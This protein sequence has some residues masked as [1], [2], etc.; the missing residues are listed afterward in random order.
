MLKVKRLK[1]SEE[2]LKIIFYLFLFLFIFYFNYRLPLDPDF[3][4]HLKYGEEVVLNKRV[5]TRDIFSHTFIGKEIIDTEWLIEALFYLIFSY[6]S[7]WGLSFFSA[8]ITTFAFFLPSLV[9]NG[10]FFKKFLITL[11]ALYGSSSVLNVGPRPQNLSL[12][13]FSLLVIFIFK[14]QEKKEIKY[15][16]FLPLIF[17]LWSNM[18]PA[19][20]VGLGVFFGFLVSEFLLADRKE[21]NKTFILFL[22]FLFSFLTSSLHPYSSEGGGKV[23][24]FEL[25][26]SLAFPLSFIDENNPL[27]R[28]R[29]TI[30]EW[31]PPTLVDFSGTLFFL[32]IAFSVGIF[33]T[34]PFSKKDFQNL[35]LNIGIIYF[36]TL[37]ARNVPFFFIFFIPLLINKIDEE[38]LL[39]AKFKKIFPMLNFSSLMIMS[40]FIPKIFILHNKIVTQ[41]SSLEAYCEARRLPCKAIDFIKKERPDGNMFNHYNLGGFLI[42]QLPEYPV[43]IDGRVPGGEIYSEFETVINLKEGWDKILEKY[44]VEWMIVPPNKLFEDF[45]TEEKTWEKIYSDQTAIILK[46]VKGKK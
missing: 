31:L 34:S 12:F 27:G 1:F 37:S 23:F 40:F 16:L 46:K 17:L 29:V 5:L 39:S 13:F 30:G 44:K 18:H 9:F 2:K 22:I 45:L 19:F 36:S 8:I 42:W 10:S 38:K 25:V 20:I 21:K 14:Y 24:S 33:L 15:F 3:G 26:R 32:G 4:W 6:W 41:G 35:F 7:F 28:V 11:W 43:F